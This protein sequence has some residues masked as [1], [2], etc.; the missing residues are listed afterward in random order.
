MFIMIEGKKVKLNEIDILIL[1]VLIPKEYGIKDKIVSRKILISNL[2]RHRESKI[3]AS[4]KKLKRYRLIAP[5]TKQGY[6]LYSIRPLGTNVFRRYRNVLGAFREKERYKLSPTVDSAMKNIQESKENVEYGG[7]IDLEKGMENPE[8]INIVRGKT[9]SN[10]I[11]YVTYGSDWDFEITT[12][13]HIK[14]DSPFP[15]SA[16]VHS[17]VLEVQQHHIIYS[18]NFKV[19]ISKTPEYLDKMCHKTA[20]QIKEEV[21]EWQRADFDLFENMERISECNKKYGRFLLEEYGLKMELIEKDKS[22]E[23]DVKKV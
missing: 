8:R 10:D 2:G 6:G 16:D 12:H 15:S 4:L 17:F 14:G 20:N 23:L 21:R 5:V 22:I 19:T 18:D 11:P 13:T 1:E 9:D 3:D 7:Y